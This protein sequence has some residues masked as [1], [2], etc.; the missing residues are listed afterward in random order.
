MRRPA[1]YVLEQPDGADAPIAAQVEPVV[2]ALRH[3]DEI[4][5]FDLDGKDSGIGRMD[6]KQAAA[7]DDHPNFVFVVPVLAVEFREHGV[8]TGRLGSDVDDVGGDVPATYFEFV[9]L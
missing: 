7:L 6:V 8:E 9:D 2:R 5:A 1:G 3:A 4:A